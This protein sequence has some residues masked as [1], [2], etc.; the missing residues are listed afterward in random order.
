MLVV[1]SLV[2]RELASSLRPKRAKAVTSAEG[3]GFASP[4]GFRTDYRPWKGGRG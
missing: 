4:S 3:I 2:I 1:F